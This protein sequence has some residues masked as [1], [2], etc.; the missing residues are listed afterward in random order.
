MGFIRD[1][2]EVMWIGGG[3]PVGEVFLLFRDALLSRESKSEEEDE[4][5]EKESSA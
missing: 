3:S 1:G 4:E 5:E 2:A